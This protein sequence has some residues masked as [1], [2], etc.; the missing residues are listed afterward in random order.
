MSFSLPR[1]LDTKLPLRNQEGVDA[2]RFGPL[3]GAQLEW[4]SED[5]RLEAWMSGLAS[6]PQRP[7][8]V[9]WGYRNNQDS[10]SGL[11]RAA[12]Q[13]FFETGNWEDR[14][15]EMNTSKESALCLLLN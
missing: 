5:R 2:G 13:R 15:E 14:R 3:W 9:F 12:E 10:I 7:G 4:L 11:G 8:A 1:V 6:L